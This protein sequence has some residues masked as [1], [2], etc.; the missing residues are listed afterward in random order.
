VVCDRFYD[1][2]TAYQGY[3]RN[4][5]LDEIRSLNRFSTAGTTPDLTLFVDVDPDEIK[6]RKIRAG[7][8]PDRMERSGDLFFR[9]V[10][11]G[12]RRIARAEPDR[13]VVVEGM[14]SIEDTHALIWEHVEKKL[15][16]TRSSP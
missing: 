14:G 10:A 7:H 12:Y 4:L 1:S 8:R 16:G 13:V 11:D 6:Q 3:G 15:S 5:P 2:T 9:M